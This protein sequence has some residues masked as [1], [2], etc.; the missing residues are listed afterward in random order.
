MEEIYFMEVLLWIIWNDYTFLKSY[1]VHSQK[2][3]KV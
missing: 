3:K 1:L 2:E